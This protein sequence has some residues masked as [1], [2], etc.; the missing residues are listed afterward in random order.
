MTHIKRLLPVAI[1]LLASHGWG[2]PRSFD[3]HIGYLYPGGGQQGSVFRV[4]VGGQ[5][6]RGVTDAHVT[7]DGVH[8]RVVKHYRPVFNID[9]EQ[10]QELQMRLVEA[11]RKQVSELPGRHR[12]L[13][14]PGM[15]RSAMGMTRTGSAQGSTASKGNAPP[16]EHPLLYGL[17]DKDLR[18]LQHVVYNLRFPRW[19]RQ[20]NLQIGET[21]LVEIAIDRGAEPGNR[22]LRLETPL[23]LTNPMVFQVGRIEE[24][25]E[26]EPN[27]PGADARLPAPP[28]Y[29]LPV[30]VNGQILPGDVDRFRFRAQR[31]QRLVIDA[32]ARRLIPYF[33]DAVPGWFQATLTLY[34]ADGS[35]LAYDDDH[36]TGPDPVLFF[37]VPETGVYELEIRDAIYRGREDFVY[38]VAV[39]EQPPIDAVDPFP[40]YEE[41]EPNDT[42]GDAQ[43]IDLPRIVNGRISRP[44][45]VD[46]F[47]LEGSAGD[48]VVA[49]VVAR[50]L[51]SPLDSLLRLTDAEGNVLEW[52]DDF[53]DGGAGLLTHHADSYLRAR[54]PNDGSYCVQLSDSQH[55]GGDGYVYRLRIG[56]PRPDFELRV[57]PSSINV[58]VRGSAPLTVHALRRDGFEGEIEIVL[59][60]SPSGFSL[61]GATIPA[62]SDGIRMTLTAGWRSRNDIV[63][64]LVEGH[65]VIDGKMVVRQAVPAE[66]MM[67]AFMYRHLVPVEELMVAVRNRPPGL[68]AT[69]VGSGLV[70]IPVDGTATVRAR[71]P[72]HPKLRDVEYELSDPP[73]GV[74]LR[75]VTAIAGG[76]ALEFEADGEVVDPGLRDN[77]IVGAYVEIENPAQGVGDQGRTRRIP[78]GVL[79]AIPFETV[80]R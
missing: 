1:V 50:R 67:Q 77:L 7:G 47:L 15:G 3:P 19:K 76:L 53:E 57:T 46:V 62:G 34:D 49:E 39:S 4:M 60:D 23:G 22:E 64:L 2:Q 75:H 14:P 80:R 13:M 54:I 58:P 74:S 10:R 25:V 44:G 63:G 55:H 73:E 24:A 20:L 29:D 35:E 41:V 16:F 8:A 27:G 5:A 56:P 6:L 45:D 31:G 9:R 36:R 42:V 65:A 61:H 30:L 69:L 72:R 43:P 37:E 66:D 32:S 48:E 33:A 26:L 51:G 71:M 28:P 40:D 70:R 11:W 12:G 18:E 21:V 52:N 79:P 78:L 38:R 17:E 68:P 59:A